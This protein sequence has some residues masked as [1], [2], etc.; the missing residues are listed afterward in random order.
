MNWEAIGAIG[1]VV[2]AAGVIGT[3]AYLAYQIR[4]NS[5]SVKLNAGQTILQSLHEALQT[6]SA[7]P[8]Q[9]RVLIHGQTDFDSLSE[10]EKIQFVA[11]M[12]SWF[13]VLEQA[14]LYQKKG[15]L[16]SEIWNGHVVHLRQIMSGS[17]MRSWWE[18]RR[19]F[20]SESF[21]AFVDEAAL[22]EAPAISVRD[23]V[24]GVRT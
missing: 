1:E 19:T 22:A 23:M 6:A 17:V 24:E 11:W 15:I 8:Q 14:H 4:Q 13:R 21:Q 9:A 20:F 2:G 12:F 18:I 10:D 3:L 5:E 16:D 7:T